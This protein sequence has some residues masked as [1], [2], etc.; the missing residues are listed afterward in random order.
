VHLVSFMH[1]ERVRTGALLDKTVIEMEIGG[2]GIQQNPVAAEPK[3]E[4]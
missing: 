1:R 2:L 3:G 4:D